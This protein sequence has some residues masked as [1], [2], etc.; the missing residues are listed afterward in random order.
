[1][2][3]EDFGRRL[4]GQFQIQPLQEELD[5]GLGLG[6]STQD[7]SALVGGGEV[8]V[9]HLDGGKFLQH[10]AGREPGRQ[11]AQAP[12]QGHVQAIGQER[13]EDVGLDAVLELVVDGAQGQIV[14]EVF[15]GRLHFGELDVKLPEFLGAA[16]AG[17]VAAQEIAALLF[18]ALAQFVFAQGEGKL[19]RAGG[20]LRLDQPRARGIFVRAGRRPLF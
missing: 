1:M 6:V 9:E 13:N 16:S 10:G 17:D 11:V 3:G 12:P 15:E 8:H 4:R 2:Q 14:F 20:D 19:G 7:D 18:A 5:V